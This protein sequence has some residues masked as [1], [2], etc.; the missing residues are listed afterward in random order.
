[1]LGADRDLDG[2]LMCMSNC[3]MIPKTQRAKGTAFSVMTANL[4]G[5]VF[6]INSKNITLIVKP[7]I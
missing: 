7:E 1:M 5:T 4:K 6:Y 3:L 2:S